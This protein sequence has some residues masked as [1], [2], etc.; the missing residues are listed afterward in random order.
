LRVYDEP[1]TCDANRLP[2]VAVL[3][4]IIVRKKGEK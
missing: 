1:A 4:V 3:A 2:L